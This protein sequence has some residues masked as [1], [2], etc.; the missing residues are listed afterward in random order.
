[1]DIICDLI[2]L[3]NV[4]TDV[5]LIGLRKSLVSITTQ[6]DL[7]AHGT[8]VK[9]PQSKAF[10]L[11]LVKGSWKQPVKSKKMQTKRSRKPR[12][13]QYGIEECRSLSRLINGTI[14]TVDKLYLD[15]L[16]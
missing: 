9:D 1:L 5:D 12:V 8:W 4:E 14:L 2:S 13:P 10:V 16:A 15:T 11:R 7:L 6:R 3:K